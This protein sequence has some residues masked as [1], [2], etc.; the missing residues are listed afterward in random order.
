[1]AKIGRESA[2]PLSF[3]R[4]NP[5]PQLQGAGRA[6]YRSVMLFPLRFLKSLYYMDFKKPCLLLLARGTST[7]M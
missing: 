6:L 7:V 2:F 1:M 4:T 3:P 5:V